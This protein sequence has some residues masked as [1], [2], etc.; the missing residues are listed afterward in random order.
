MGGEG[1]HSSGFPTRR[2]GRTL[3]V[4][5]YHYTLHQIHREVSRPST[6]ASFAHGRRAALIATITTPLGKHKAVD[7]ETHPEAITATVR[8]EDVIC[9]RELPNICAARPNTM[10]EATRRLL[11]QLNRRWL[12]GKLVSSLYL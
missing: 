11:Y 3:S 6:S 2:I 5:P 8:L 4:T 10:P 9:K 12:Y 1:L 7:H